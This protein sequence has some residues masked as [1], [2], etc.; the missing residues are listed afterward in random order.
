MPQD[1]GDAPH[2]TALLAMTA[3]RRARP[4]S[5]WACDAPWLADEGSWP[6]A[7]AL[8]LAHRDRARDGLLRHLASLEQELCFRT[9]D[10]CH[11][12]GD[13]LFWETTTLDGEIDDE[14]DAGDGWEDQE[15]PALRPRGHHTAGRA[16]NPQVGVG[17]ALTRDGWPGRSWVFPGNTA[18]VTTITHLKDDLQGWRLHRCVCVGESGMF[19]EAHR[20]RLS[21]ALGRDILAVP[22]RQV[23]AVPLDVLPRAGRSRAV[24]HTLR[25]KA[26]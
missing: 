26:V 2:E 15:I 19:S 21:R 12:D 13:L 9:A 8:A 23:T 7:K 1:G 10:L 18:E 14:D 16:G 3:N 4:A 17:L 25:V 22:M 20:Q 6:E 11:A 5:T 24:A